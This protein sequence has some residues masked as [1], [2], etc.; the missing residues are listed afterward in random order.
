MKTPTH[1]LIGYGC[2]Q[3]FGWRGTAR[4]A[5][6][7]GA[8]APDIP[9]AAVWMALAT[10]VTWREGGFAQ[11]VVQREMDA[12][13]FSDSV[14]IGLH[15]LLH[16]PLSL[17]GLALLATLLLRAAPDLGRCCLAFL[18]GAMTHALADIV[19]H[20]NDG[21]LLFW[22][23]DSGLRLAGPFSHWDPAHGGLWISAMELIC[24]LAGGLWLL[25]RRWRRPLAAGRA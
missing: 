15:N 23:L 9:V 5:C 10:K 19:S 14:V 3:L 24:A 1:L 16:A 11:P 2:A 13:Y 8:V 12:L 22:P 21:P 20:V 4:R 18:A 6:L 17:L 25:R 7:L